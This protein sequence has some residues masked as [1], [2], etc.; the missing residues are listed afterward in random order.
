MSPLPRGDDGSRSLGAVQRGANFTRCSL[1]IAL[2][3]LVSQRAHP[4]D[5]SPQRVRATPRRSLLLGFRLRLERPVVSE[6]AHDV[7]LRAV[8]VTQVGHV[9]EEDAEFSGSARALVG[10]KEVRGLV[11][12]EVHRALVSGGSTY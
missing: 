12:G 9:R 10:G 5:L 3:K 7:P 4:F 2:G 11:V 1:P 8:G 6:V